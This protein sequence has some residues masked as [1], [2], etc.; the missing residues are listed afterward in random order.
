MGEP[1]VDVE[2]CVVAG[3]IGVAVGEAGVGVGVAMAMHVAPRDDRPNRTTA[4]E[5][6]LSEI[7]R[8]AADRVSECGTRTLIV[9][10]PWI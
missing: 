9:A 6:N 3:G 7:H 2:D 1:G 8:L 4:M 5:R 10:Q